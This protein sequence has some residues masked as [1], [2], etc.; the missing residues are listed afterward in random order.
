MQSIQIYYI[1]PTFLKTSTNFSYLGDSRPY[2]IYARAQYPYSPT[3]QHLRIE[4]GEASQN[5]H[6]GIV[7]TMTQRS[8]QSN[9]LNVS[10]LAEI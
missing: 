7:S 2:G 10:I 9:L 3:S 8:I 5:L 1:P 4:C 6:I